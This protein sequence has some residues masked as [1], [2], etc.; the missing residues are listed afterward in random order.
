[1]NA[2]VF[3]AILAMDSYNRGYGAG[4]NDLTEG[5]TIGNAAVR[6]FQVG[7]Q[8]GWQAAG[9]YASAYSWN[10]KTVISYR[11]TNFDYSLSSWQAFVDSPAVKDAKYGWTLGAGF[12][13]ADQ[14]Q[15][16]IQFYNGVTGRG[17]YAG[18][19]PSIL[20]TGHSLGGGLAG[21][22][23]SLSRN[24]AKTYDHMPFG[25]A[26]WSQ[27][28]YDSL[29]AACTQTG[30]SFDDIKNVL[31]GSPTLTFLIKE[32]LTL[33]QFYTSFNAELRLR[34]PS[35][36][37]IEGISTVGEVLQYVRD[38][39]VPIAIGGITGTL[40][41]ILGAPALGIT[42]L[43]DYGDSLLNSTLALIHGLR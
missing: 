30:V 29:Q 1:M 20:L 25:I 7:E 12:S 33:N 14:G 22:V 16:A 32:G 17:I 6:S 43:R 3:R 31:S 35:F 37:G 4:V 2:D 19:D 10:G 18:R 42:G 39:T 41:D 26:A 5:G 36:A 23:A 13:G 40:L 28:I 24:N 21:F 27:A 8:D 38:G 9:F 34:K 11:G 15:L